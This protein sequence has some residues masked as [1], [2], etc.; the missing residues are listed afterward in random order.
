MLILS[1]YTA[2]SDVRAVL[3]V[4]TD[5]LPDD[6]LNTALYADSL[7]AVLKLTDVDNAV[8]GAG[9]LFDKYA[10]IIAVS[11][12]SR[13]ADQI[14]MKTVIRLLCTY[15]VAQVVIPGLSMRAKKAETDG[16]SAAT[17]FSA[18]STFQ[19]VAMLIESKIASYLDLAANIGTSSS[20]ARIPIMLGVATPATDIIEETVR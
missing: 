16:K 3:G 18:E 15:Y 10:T 9:S 13:T 11:E 17:R 12:G 4:D 14:N 1:E 5:E 19:D 8:G 6:E 7:E 2:C 20:A